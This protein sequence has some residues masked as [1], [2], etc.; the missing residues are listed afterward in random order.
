MHFMD[1]VLYFEYMISRKCMNLP[2]FLFAM[3]VYRNCLILDPRDF[4]A[5]S[6]V[7]SMILSSPKLLKAMW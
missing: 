6:N 1:C 4:Q 7:R 3:I 5:I 2:H